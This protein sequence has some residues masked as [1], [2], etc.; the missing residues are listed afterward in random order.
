MNLSYIWLY[1]LF[2]GNINK[3]IFRPL[4]NY[5]QSRSVKNARTLHQTLFPHT[6]IFLTITPSEDPIT[7][8]LIVY[9]RSLI[10]VSVRIF[11]AKTLI[12][13]A[14]LPAALIAVSVW[15]CHLSFSSESIIN[16]LTLI[17]CSVWHD[18][19]TSKLTIFGVIPS[20]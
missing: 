15:K 3:L 13:Y 19:P 20:A 17:Y 5:L 18:Q 2:A 4:A 9:Q 16:K 10:S 6:L 14:L 8:L 1:R 7:T 12:K 11:D